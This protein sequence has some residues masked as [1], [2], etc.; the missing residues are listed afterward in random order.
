MGI[1]IWYMICIIPFIVSWRIMHV[2]SAFRAWALDTLHISNTTQYTTNKRDRER[3]IIEFAWAISASLKPWRIF[4]FFVE[5]KVSLKPKRKA[6][7]KQT[8]KGHPN[9]SRGYISFFKSNQVEDRLRIKIFIDQTT[10]C[11]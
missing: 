4:L 2:S 6:K 5:E 1:H 11:Y 7:N 10:K 3:E 9:S 8:R